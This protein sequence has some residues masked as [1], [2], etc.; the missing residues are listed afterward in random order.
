MIDEMYIVS[1]QN[2]MGYRVL[3]CIEHGWFKQAKLYHE[4]W[5]EL[6]RLYKE[7]GSG[8]GLTSR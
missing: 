8:I 4:A 3:L 2:W 6:D 7:M 1:Y 5:R